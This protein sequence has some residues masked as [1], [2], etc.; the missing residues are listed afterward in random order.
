MFLEETFL[1]NYKETESRFITRERNCE[2]A[3][4]FTPK[5]YSHRPPSNQ[6]IGRCTACRSA[7]AKKNEINFWLVAEVSCK[8]CFPLLVHPMAGS[9]CRFLLSAPIA[10]TS[11]ADRALISKKVN[12]KRNTKCAIRIGQQGRRLI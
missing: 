4:E 10:H 6:R 9:Y 12:R 8:S 11:S 1:V 5:R 3:C 7:F 2:L